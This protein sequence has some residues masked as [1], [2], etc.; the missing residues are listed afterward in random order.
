MSTGAAHVGARKRKFAVKVKPSSG[1]T[2]GSLHDDLPSRMK[3]NLPELFA[4]PRKHAK[5]DDS[6]TTIE[7]AAS[8]LRSNDEIKP[9]LE[10]TGHE[11]EAQLPSHDIVT[12]AESEQEDNRPFVEEATI[13][14]SKDDAP[15]VEKS[16]YKDLTISDKPDVEGQLRRMLQLYGRSNFGGLLNALGHSHTQDVLQRPETVTAFI[17]FI[18]TCTHCVLR[19]ARWC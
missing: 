19:R 1:S 4:H 6:V 2:S 10:E 15:V 9:A 3:E 7:R 5:S 12:A 18:R 14:Y 17:Q 16:H 13:F 11:F 8:E